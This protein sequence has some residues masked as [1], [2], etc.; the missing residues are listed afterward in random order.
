M[1]YLAPQRI[2]RYAI[3]EFRRASR[4]TN[5][6]CKSLIVNL[7]LPVIVSF[8]YVILA[9]ARDAVHESADGCERG[10]LGQ[11]KWIGFTPLNCTRVTAIGRRPI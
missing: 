6:P 3:S 9:H 11:A 4:A 5:R 8:S 2:S 1:Y 10:I 7:H